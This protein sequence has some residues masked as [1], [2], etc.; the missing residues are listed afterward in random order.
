MQYVF[1][2]F[3]LRVLFFAVVSFYADDAALALGQTGVRS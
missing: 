3:C 2:I 1:N